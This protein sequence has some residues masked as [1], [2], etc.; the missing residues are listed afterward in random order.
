MYNRRAL[1]NLFFRSFLFFMERRHGV[2]TEEHVFHSLINDDK[3][4]EL[5]ELCTLDF[6]NLDKILEEFFNKLPL[7]KSNVSDYAFKIN[8]LYQEIIS[9][10]FYYKKPYKI[11]EKDLLWVLVRKRQNTILDA[12][13]KSGFN[14]AIFDKM[15]EV[16]DYLGA[17]SNLGLV[18]NERTGPA[19]VDDKK[20]DKE[21]GFDIFQEEHFRLENDN[22]SLD[23]SSPVEGF[24]VNV[25]DSLDPKL[26][27]NPLIGRDRELNK[28]IQVM[29]RRHKSNPI[30]IGEPGVGKTVLI[31]G[32]AYMIKVDKVP[33][34]LRGYGLYALGIGKL[35]SGTRYRGD[36]E[37]RVNKVLDFLYL[38]KKTILFIDEIHMIVGA[39]ATSFSSIDI[40]NLLKPI[41][42][43]GKV[44][45]IGATTE[46]EYKKFFL[47]DKALARRFHSIELK[48]PGFEDTYLI[49]KG[50]KGQYEKHHNVEYTEGAIRA[51]ITMSCKY[52]K[53]KFLPD[54]AFDLLDELGAKF[55]LENNKKIIT[56]ND[57]KDFIKSIVDTSIFNLEDHDDVFFVSLEN[58]IRESVI[59]NEDVLSDLILNIKL[60]KV[61]FLF[62][63]NALGIFVFMSSS[64]LD[65][66]KLLCILSEELKLPRFTLGM[67][68]YSD[69]DAINRLIGPMYASDSYDEPARFFKFLSRYS[70][71]VI[72]LSD[73]DKAHKRVIDFFSQGFSTGKFCDS[74]GR[75]FSL[76]D[77]III[78]DINTE[79]REFNS[80]GFKNEIASGRSLLERR[81]SSQFLDLVDHIFFFRPVDESGFEQV[82]REEI[83]HFV[84]LLKEKEINVF[85]EESILGYFKSKTYGSGFGI[86]S[87]RK[88]VIKE[89]GSLLINEM[90]LKKIKKNDRIRIY[91]ED[92]M[93]YELL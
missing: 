57:V 17:D 88:I 41:L 19:C 56:E 45:F 2:F 67:S 71:S 80:I 49:L 77:S 22:S 48:E 38:K 42:T 11:Q 16:Y 9:T 60:L 23:D 27:Q 43:L 92:R 75:N 39:G 90:N 50:V 66:D 44:K 20:I 52:I 6:Y 18:G 87:V 37:D 35:I 62:E 32:L 24:L 78:V 63:S 65:K 33:Q 68:E 84:R 79:S 83:N 7:R 4:R 21:G 5:L 10:I 15:I 61:K 89:I 46:Y 53:D 85:F 59:I 47:R 3:I 8:D 76:S 29:L 64:D 82:I 73:F 1:N 13:L 34:E 72:F 30:L 12:L 86:K 70:S 28:L 31:Q 26:E 55:K 58:K 93:R 54:K 36:L 14:L 91:L 69:F 74:F 25:I 81:F 51:S 40:S